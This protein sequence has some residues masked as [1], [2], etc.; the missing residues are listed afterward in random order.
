MTSVSMRFA[1]RDQFRKQLFS[2]VPEAEK[3]LAAANE[4][5]AAEFM[6]MA[7]RLAPVHSGAVRNSIR[8]YPGQRP[9]AWVVEAGGPTTTKP[10]RKGVKA[11]Y[12]YALGVEFGTSDTSRK[13]FFWPAYRAQK[14]PAKGRATRALRK[15]IKAKGF[16]NG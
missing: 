8:M 9:G 14:R 3:E 6:A 11:T 5:S 12:D 4:K 7:Q 2:V 15:A 13:S 10:V 16:G 1:N